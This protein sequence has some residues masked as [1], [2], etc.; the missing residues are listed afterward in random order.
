MRGPRR[1]A[2]I[3]A[4]AAGVLLVAEV[5]ARALQPALAEP[6][7]WPDDATA[8]KIAQMDDL[9]CADVVFTGNSVARDDLVPTAFGEHAPDLVAYNAALDA[10]AP[11]QLAGWVPDEVV[12]RLDPGVVVWV[13]TSPDLND[14][15]PAAAAAADSYR[16]SIGGRDDVLGRIQRTLVDEV[17]LVR[18]RGELTDPAG[19]WDAAGDRIAGEDAP[20]LDPSG[21]PGLIGPGGEGLSRASLEYVAGDPV[22]TAFVRDQL[23]ADFDLG[24]EQVARAEDLVADLR[25]DGREVVLVLPPVTPEFVELHPGGQEAFEDYGAAMRSLADDT[26]AELIDLRDVAEPEW[27]ADT[28]HLNGTGAAAFSATVADELAARDLL[29]AESRCGNRS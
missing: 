18:H 3:V 17:A 15:A 2:T 16:S 6:E 23:L 27:F 20:R 10:A 14:N 9:G 25:A 8:L 24:G 4:V 13:V 11:R 7:I 22:V 26:G 21:L 29:P 1:I 5:S 19:L 28:H 12:P